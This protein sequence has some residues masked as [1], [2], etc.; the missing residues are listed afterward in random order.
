MSDNEIAVSR[1]SKS[2]R[3]VQAVEHLSFVVEPGRVTGFL[4]P[5]GAGKKTT[6][7]MMLGLVSPSSGTVRFGGRSYADMPAPLREVGSLLD[8]N[9]VHGARTGRDHLRIMCPMGGIN[10]R[11]VDEVLELVDLT[12]A[13]RRRVKGYSLGMRQR[14]GIAKA[15]LG[16]PR[17]LIL[18]EP[19][20][21]LDPDGIR[22]LRKLLRGLADDGRTVLVSS[23]LLGEMQLMA[24]DVII[25]ARGRLI[26]QGSLAQVI[27]SATGAMSHVRSPQADVLQ[28]ALLSAG[29]EVERQ[30]PGLLLVGNCDMPQIGRLALDVRAEIHELR[31][32]EVDL[33]SAFFRLTEGKAG[34]R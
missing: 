7:R 12:Q 30:G 14:L 15:M 27:S 10:S 22:W 5:N 28:Q 9:D 21:G 24:D 1:L 31:P 20:N 34:I 13:A 17:V 19:A 11:R 33:E 8:A 32:V 3:N 6:L 26:Q 2:Y 25:I 18:D 29:A 23:H 16:N 4:G